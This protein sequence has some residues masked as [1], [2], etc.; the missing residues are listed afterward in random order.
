MIGLTVVVCRHRRRCRLVEWNWRV[1]VVWLDRR[2]YCA[3]GVWSLDPRLMTEL[4]YWNDVW[5]ALV[6]PTGVSCCGYNL[7]R[8]RPVL[9]RK[10]GVLA[11]TYEMWLVDGRFL[12]T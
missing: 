11:G 9:D 7:I 12:L 3:A 5:L 1:D 10:S 4:N 8:L 6:T 2:F